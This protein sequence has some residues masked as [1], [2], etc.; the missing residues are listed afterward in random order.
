MASIVNC[1]SCSRR[2]QVPDELFGQK[3]KCPT[4]GTIF[5][6]GEEEPPLLGPHAEV[7]ERPSRRSS[8][9]LP[10][11]VV[12]DRE[13]DE[14]RDRFRRRWRRDEDDDDGEELVRRERRAPP[15]QVQAI[16]VM[17]LVGGIL[18]IVLALGLGGAFCCLWP[19]A[20]YS[21][22][23]GILATIKGANL[24]GQ[25]A[26]REKAPHAIAIMMICNIVNGDVV[27]LTMGILILVFL[28]DR[29]VRRYYRG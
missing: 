10:V 22:V 17:I 9:S 2:L 13:K 18:A 6:G 8:A 25:H 4:C 12:E 27:N 24:L 29:A 14:D 16:A 11:P 3:V 15:G 5:T 28:N 21:L 7:E 19:G 23:L 26:R 20:Y 1:P